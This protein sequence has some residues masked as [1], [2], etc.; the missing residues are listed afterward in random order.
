MS[1]ARGRQVEGRATTTYNGNC[2]GQKVEAQHQVSLFNCSRRIEARGE[3]EERRRREGT[4]HTASQASK[5][6]YIKRLSLDGDVNVQLERK[7]GKARLKEGPGVGC[8]TSLL[9]FNVV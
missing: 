4:V 8:A 1:F 6:V 9:F 7:K 2:H 3:E 5:Q